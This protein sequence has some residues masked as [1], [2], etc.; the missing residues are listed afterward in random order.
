MTLKLL[1]RKPGPP[2]HHAPKCLCT[3]RALW[4]QSF[5]SA[6]LTPVHVQGKMK[7]R[8]RD[9]YSEASVINPPSKYFP[10]PLFHAFHI[11]KVIGPFARS[12]NHIIPGSLRSGQT[13]LV[14]IPDGG[15]IWEGFYLANL[16][17]VKLEMP[18]SKNCR[19]KEIDQKWSGNKY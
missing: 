15:I 4:T 18:T 3:K 10:P 13:L 14:I 5:V 17:K 12:L 11:H 8:E 16:K 7:R 9:L 6:T 2:H 1:E 19:P